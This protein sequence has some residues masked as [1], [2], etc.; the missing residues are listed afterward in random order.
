MVHRCI[1]VLLCGGIY[2]NNRPRLFSEDFLPIGAGLSLFTPSDT[3]FIK[4]DIHVVFGGRTHKVSGFVKKIP[5]FFPRKFGILKE[6]CWNVESRV[7]FSKS[8]LRRKAHFSPNS[9]IDMS[10]QLEVGFGAGRSQSI[11]PPVK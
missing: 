8:L 9:F 1:D 10:N 7:A 6:Q 2:E 5:A 4:T 11:S 3:L